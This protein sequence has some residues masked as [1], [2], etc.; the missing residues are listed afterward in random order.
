[1][2]DPLLVP[3]GGSVTLMVLAG[4]VEDS[5]AV[6]LDTVT[7]SGF[8]GLPFPGSVESSIS[9]LFQLEIGSALNVRV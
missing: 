6:V 4:A 9:P 1:L 3:T 8:V 7:V 2:G 5:P